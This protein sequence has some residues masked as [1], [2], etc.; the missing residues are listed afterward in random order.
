MGSIVRRHDLYVRSC[1]GGMYSQRTTR[2][3]QATATENVPFEQA[4]AAD[5][6]QKGT[7]PILIRWQLQCPHI[8][9]T[10]IRALVRP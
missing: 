7:V 1:T 4:A 10:T 6:G 2:S 8:S 9:E 3:I 5:E